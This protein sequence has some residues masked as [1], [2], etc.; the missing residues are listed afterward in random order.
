MKLKSNQRIVWVDA[1]NI[2]ACAG[3]LLLH[4]T[5]NQVH[6]FS[7]TPSWDWYVG[8]FTHSTFLWPVDVFFM[9]SGYT[10]IRSD[11]Q[12]VIKSGGGKIVL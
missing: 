11:I 6:N 2:V 7:G 9:L 3:V 8:L 4:C 10:I 12:F 1:L 5:N